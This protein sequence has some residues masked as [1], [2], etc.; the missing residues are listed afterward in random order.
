MKKRMLVILLGIIITLS[1]CDSFESGSDLSEE[2]DYLNKIELTDDQIQIISNLEEFQYVAYVDE[3]VLVTQEGY[4]VVYTED[5]TFRQ[6]ETYISISGIWNS[7][8]IF[9]TIA[10]GSVT[11]SISRA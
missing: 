7:S 5:E 11:F 9:S 1:G 2:Y 4:W 3:D 6:S 8:V 10:P